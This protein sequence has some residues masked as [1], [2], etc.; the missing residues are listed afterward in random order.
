MRGGHQVHA[1]Y[2]G[3]SLQV[4][5]LWGYS[6]L[7]ASSQ[8]LATYPAHA[9]VGVGVGVASSGPFR[10]MGGKTRQT[11]QVV[12]EEVLWFVLTCTF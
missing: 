2:R 11:M 12:M 7:A 8:L 6:W 1:G 5:R 9:W 3:E 4:G 10:F